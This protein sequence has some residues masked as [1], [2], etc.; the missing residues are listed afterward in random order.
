MAK[1]WNFCAWRLYM[2]ETKNYYDLVLS[3]PAVKPLK[4]W[5]FWSC[6]ISTGSLFTVHYY[7]GFLPTCAG[8][9]WSPLKTCPGQGRNQ[10]SRTMCS[11]PPM[12]RHGQ[13]PTGEFH[14]WD[15][16]ITV[17]DTLAARIS[18]SSER[19]HLH[20]YMYI[21]IHSFWGINPQTSPNILHHN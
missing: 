2:Y 4:L 13:Y 21:Y 5:D 20:M 7:T 9:G 1:N 11:A 19:I 6:G 14:T 15:I 16:T 12:C 8:D 10:C 3:N 17:G 18:K